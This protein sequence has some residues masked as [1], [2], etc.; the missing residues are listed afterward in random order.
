V[1][2]EFLS[3]DQAAGFGR[4][5]GDVPQANLE[6]FFYL[7]DADRDLI[8]VR[9]GDHNR[10]GFAVQLGTVRFLGVF[11]PDSLD[12]PWGVVEYLAAQ[13]QVTDPQVVKRYTQRVSTVHEHARAIRAAYG[14]RDFDAPLSEELTLFVY[15]C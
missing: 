8:S 4:F 5:A 1:P 3:D 6:Q 11:L 12:V 9:R 7:D 14:Y 13:L 2:V 10:L 15:S